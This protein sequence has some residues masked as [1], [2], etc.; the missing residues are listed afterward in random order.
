MLNHFKSKRNRWAKKVI[1]SLVLVLLCAC[2]EQIVHNLAEHEANRLLT[3]LNDVQID[4][5]KVKQPDGKWAISVNKSESLK[6]IKYLNDARVVREFQTS[7]TEK[8][9]MISS[10]EDQRFR[11]ER[12]LSKEIENTLASIA[13]VLEARVHL[14]LPQRDP[15]FGQRIDSAPGSASVLLI[16]V[17]ASNVSAVEVAALVAGA[18]GVEKER[19]SVLVSEAKGLGTLESDTLVAEQVQMA[20]EQT[21]PALNQDQ[22]LVEARSLSESGPGLLA[23]IGYLWNKHPIL[24]KCAIALVLLGCACLYFIF[25]PLRNRRGNS[26][27]WSLN[28]DTGGNS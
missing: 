27:L 18:S 10:R 17:R 11:Y 3:R 22:I 12:S 23:R 19:I 7:Q 24:M 25:I 4:S 8:P 13:G 1:T 2:E 6:A 21:L 15:L 20:Q 14:N 26:T 28:V 5:E 16:A 9:S